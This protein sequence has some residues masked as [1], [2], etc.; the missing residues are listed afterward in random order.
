MASNMGH[1]YINEDSVNHSSKC[2]ICNQP[3]VRPVSTNCR[4][5]HKF[6]RQCIEQWLKSNSSCPTYIVIDVLNELRVK[7]A[8][9]EQT[10][11]ERDD[12]NNRLNYKY[13]SITV[14][15]PAYDIKC[16]WR[17]SRDQLA[18]HVNKCPYQSLRP[19]VV[20]LLNENQELKEQMTQVTK[21]MKR[22]RN[23]IQQLKEQVKQQ[24]TK[25]DDHSNEMIQMKSL[26]IPNSSQTSSVKHPVTNG[27]HIDYGD[28]YVTS[29]FTFKRWK[30]FP[31]NA[32]A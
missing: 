20:S 2:S 29:Y 7:Y 8:A 27:Y 5:K 10:E 16:S 12:F 17:G 22:Y 32:Q 24:T 28:S 18:N 14:K 23:E 30:K 6:C 9:C 3:F 25:I 21:Q 19:L 13:P 1:E 15:C 26:Y 4:R 11:F 31:S